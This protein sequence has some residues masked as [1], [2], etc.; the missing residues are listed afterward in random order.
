MLLRDK[1]ALITGGARGIGLACAEAFA[2][3]GANVVIVDIRNDLL[4]SARKRIEQIGRQALVLTCDVTSASD[5]RQVIDQ[6][7]STFGSV[8]TCVHSAAIVRDMDFFEITAEEWNA[9]LEVNLTGAFLTGQ[10]VA[11]QMRNQADG[12]TIVFI[13]SIEATVAHPP[14]IPYLASKGGLNQL[15]RGMAVRLA[16]EGVR[17][18]AVSPGSTKTEQLKVV[19]K[20]PVLRNMQLSRTP[21][22]RYA[23]PREI[24]NAALFLASGLSSYIVGQALV[25]DGGRLALHYTVPVDED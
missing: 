20:D 12:G 23:E 19:A 18:N 25:A 17:V 4:D 3:A 13:S 10:A 21:I 15:M 8:D 5:L 9:H 22:G 11:Q 24:A 7:V 16:K 6:T 1:V 14:L 2:E